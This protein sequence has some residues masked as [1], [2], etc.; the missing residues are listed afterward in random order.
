MSWVFVPFLVAG[1]LAPALVGL[2]VAL[3]R[4]GN[5][6]AWILLLGSCRWRW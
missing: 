1:I 6:V 3:R 4:P 2:F 5:P